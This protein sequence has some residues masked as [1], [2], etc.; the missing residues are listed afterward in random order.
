M[1][2]VRALSSPTRSLSQRTGRTRFRVIKIERG[3]LSVS[4][5]VGPTPPTGG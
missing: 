1:S 2:F 3:V 5:A 4:Y